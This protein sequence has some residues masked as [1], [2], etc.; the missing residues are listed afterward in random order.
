MEPTE[1][2]ELVKTTLSDLGFSDAKS[3]GCHL[4]FRNRHYAG[5]HFMFEG[6]SAIWLADSDDLKFFDDSKKLLKIVRLVAN[7]E[8]VKQAA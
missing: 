8:T 2:R 4:V 7:Q 1:V 6:V 5:I 3:L